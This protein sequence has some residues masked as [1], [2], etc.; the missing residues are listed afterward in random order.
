MQWTGTDKPVKFIQNQSM[1][2]FAINQK[3]LKQVLIWDVA[4]DIKQHAFWIQNKVAIARVSSQPLVPNSG[5][6]KTAHALITEIA[7]GWLNDGMQQ[8]T[9]CCQL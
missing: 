2:D 8:K 7:Y 5:V 4:H 3:Q 1:C 6:I 9:T